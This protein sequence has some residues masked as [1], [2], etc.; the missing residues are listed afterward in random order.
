MISRKSVKRYLTGL[1]RFVAVP[2]T[3]AE[4]GKLDLG[5]TKEGL[6]KEWVQAAKKAN[7]KA[8]LSIGGWSG[9][10][11]QTPFLSDLSWLLTPAS[12]GRLQH[13][14]QLS[15]DGAVTE[16]LCYHHLRYTRYI[17]IRWV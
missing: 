16:R 2:G 13:L 10:T 8:M 17:R 6:A 12:R 9:T 14:F 7:C 3:V 5:E 1:D 11:E 4:K 15:G